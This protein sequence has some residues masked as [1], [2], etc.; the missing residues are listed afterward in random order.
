MKN[1]NQSPIEYS[2]MSLYF[3]AQVR[4]HKSFSQFLSLFVAF[5]MPSITDSIST[6]VTSLASGRSWL[7]GVILVGSLGLG[8]VPPNLTPPCWMAVSWASREASL[9]SLDLALS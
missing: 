3:H 4:Y 2:I 9:S 7:R 6:S 5:P 8:T 1:T